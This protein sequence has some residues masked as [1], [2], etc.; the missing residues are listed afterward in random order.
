MAEAATVARTGAPP[1]EG[2]DVGI[3]RDRFTV[4][5]ARPLA[6]LDLPSANAFVAEDR[7][8]P[9]YKLFALIGAPGL[10]P[11]TGALAALKGMTGRGLLPLIDYG[12]VF[13][14][15][16]GR[17]CMAAIYEQPLGGRV[18]D[19]IASEKL[20]VS[21]HEIARRVI[22]PLFAALR[23]FSELGIAH[24]EIRPSN[25]FFMDEA[26]EN[27]VLGDCAIVPPGFDQPILFS[28]IENGLAGPGGRGE[29][30][31]RDDIYALGV[32]IIAI[33][34]DELPAAK[35]SDDDLLAAK[36]ENGSSGA[37]SNGVRI[38]LSLLE[39]LRGMLTDQIDERWGFDQI[40]GWMNG[41]KMTPMQRRA[42][43]KTD[44]P[45]TFAGYTHFTARTLAHGMAQHVGEAAKFLRETDLD[46]WVRRALA[47][48]EAADRV[49]TAIDQA[50]ANPNAPT[51][52]DDHLVAR[53]VM[54]LDPKGPIRY[55]GVSYLPTGF[56][57]ALAVELLRRGEAQALVETIAREYPAAWY[58][59]PANFGPETPTAT[60]T[61]T[62]IRTHLQNNDFG[63][64]VERCL[65]EFNPSLPCQSPLVVEEYVTRIEELLPALDRAASR[66]DPKSRP[67]DR[68]IA[69]FIAARFHQNIDPHLKALASP[70]SETS[71]IGMLSLLAL[72]QWRL[73]LEGLLGLAG[74]I[75]G[76]LGP[77][78]NVF[79]SR[80]TRR[81]IEKEIPRLVR[82][83]S[84]P[85]M[86]NL[87]DSADKR[88]QD[89]DGYIAAQAGFAA[90][91]A[92]IREVEG[93]GREQSRA[94]TR[95]QQTSA[96]ISLVIA[97]LVVFSA[98]M[99]QR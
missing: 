62:Q 72:V 76:L 91:E 9:S 32:S 6:H 5:P 99:L 3:L 26:R 59:H 51:S 55:K 95:G 14:A 27:I 60:R 75:G 64:G 29:G 49:K 21:E 19:L 1:R 86:F 36:I 74:W 40:D 58:S 89:H 67:I 24:R 79:H 41:R 98:L 28:T 43:A 7:R 37:L 17:K 73:K 90:A 94:M 46:T 87:I 77:A 18:S 42:S 54:A 82:Q 2:S 80:S 45:L 33:L 68:H 23:S 85:E 8:D 35:L 70:R 34:F 78:I 20:R 53:V 4:Y 66:V 48:P 12:P 16:L 50:R 22:G 84:L 56:G 13:W 93:G 65:Y 63:F 15:P 25:M 39:P 10:P 30:E 61:F 83:G 31:L 81:E 52:S 38:P 97:V 69:A 92:E 88:R 71:L 96:V 11:R 44:V 57:S 47:D